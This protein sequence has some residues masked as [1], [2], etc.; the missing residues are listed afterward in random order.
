VIRVF[1]VDDHPALRAGL[2]T[3]F[4]LEPGFGYAGE[5]AGDEELWPL[6]ARADADVLLADYHLP[7]G[8]GLQLCREAR[9]RHPALRTLLYSAYASPTLSLPAALAGIDAMVGK[10][11]GARE[12]FDVLRG[13][14]RGERLLAPPPIAVLEE[15]REHLDPTEQAL[16]GLLLDGTT[17]PEAGEVIGLADPALDRTVRRMIAKLRID[18]PELPA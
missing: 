3:V 11:A 9:R 8:D 18:V 17:E 16:V 5:S 12:L 6:L 4:L 2:R 13:V 14:K 7:S 10:D 15:A 1:I